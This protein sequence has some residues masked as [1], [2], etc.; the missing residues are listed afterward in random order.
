MCENGETESPS[1]EKMDISD[2]SSGSSHMPGLDLGTAELVHGSSLDNRPVPAARTTTKPTPAPRET[3]LDKDTDNSDRLQM[4][5]LTQKTLQ[6][7]GL[8]L[9]EE[10]ACEGTLDDEEEDASIYQAVLSPDCTDVRLLKDGEEETTPAE[11]RKQSIDSGAN[12]NNSKQQDIPGRSERS[13]STAST[14]DCESL[15]MHNDGTPTG[16]DLEEYYEDV[17]LPEGQQ[18]TMSRQESFRRRLKGVKVEDAAEFARIGRVVASG[19]LSKHDSIRRKLVGHNSRPAL[20][21]THF[22]EGDPRALWAKGN[23]DDAWKRSED[24]PN[25]AN[26][27][28]LLSYDPTVE[29]TSLMLMLDKA[30]L[31][32]SQV[33]HSVL[34]DTPSLNPT[35]IVD[36]ATLTKVK[37]CFDSES[38]KD[39]YT[40]AGRLQ[41]LLSPQEVEEIIR[42]QTVYSVIL[43]RRIVS[44]L[45]LA[46]EEP[47]SMKSQ[48]DAI[49]E[50]KKVE[51]EQAAQEDN[52]EDAEEGEG[53][54]M[55]VRHDSKR[56]NATDADRVIE[57]LFI[58]SKQ[59]PN[60]P[61]QGRK[62]LHLSPDI[63]DNEPQSPDELHKSFS[64]EDESTPTEFPSSQHT[65]VS[66]VTE[67]LLPA[68]CL[69]LDPANLP[70]APQPL[71]RQ[72]ASGPVSTAKGQTSE[73]DDLDVSDILSLDSPD[74]IEESIMSRLSQ[75][76]V[77]PLPELTAAEERA[78]ERNWR[79][80]MVAGLERQID[81]KVIAPY[82][83]VLHHGGYLGSGAQ[84]AIIVFTACYLPDRYVLTTLD[85]L[86]AEN[87]VLVY[88]HGAT[89]RSCMPSF[90][91]LKR[92]YHMIDRRLR[93]NLKGLYLVHPTFWLKTIVV[94]TRP[95]VSTKFSRKLSFVETLTDLAQLVPLEQI[96][97][98]ERVKQLDFQLNVKKRRGYLW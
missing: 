77:A 7:Q 3:S 35:S 71:S 19:E 11:K 44:A 84:N 95:F 67:K 72:L 78:E 20:F 89:A 97:I 43:D 50:E 60:A 74:E 55:F 39:L 36:D 59:P 73:D 81:M 29:D 85:Q 75:Q 16:G 6:A 86:V 66:R 30:Q 53:G 38:F 1:E 41:D 70:R 13:Y 14:V 65:A 18:Y 57:G 80:C 46:V 15:I 76:P 93:K 21:P 51:A 40:L 47:K 79:S 94:M 8:P 17:P 92:C 91:W 68:N 82:K 25:N 58:E 64:P 22:E 9:T 63:L 12:V 61:K 69:V 88:L 37:A 54:F 33:D 49:T 90:G 52:E 62:L 32:E 42:N 87:Y 96:T 23:S 31:P 5:L 26:S 10:E 98:P 83:R 48:V 34:A 4:K 45:A 24:D 28:P 2:A 56:L 27:D